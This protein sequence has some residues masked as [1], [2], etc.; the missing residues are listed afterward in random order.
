MSETCNPIYVPA[1]QFPVKDSGFI[2]CLNFI[3]RCQP[4]LWI[5]LLFNPRPVKDMFANRDALLV[6]SL[7]ARFISLSLF[8]SFS[9]FIGS[10]TRLHSTNR[11]P[12][13]VENKRKCGRKE[14]EIEAFIQSIGREQSVVRI[15]IS[16]TVYQLLRQTN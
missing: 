10:R 11:P 4:R 3:P 1:F 8:S 2:A 14:E 15:Y 9:F 16:E 12:S 6:L 5:A 13:E 7:P